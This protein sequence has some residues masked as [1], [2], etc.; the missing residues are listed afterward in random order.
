MT[1]WCI[2][3]GETGELRQL[4]LNDPADL[5]LALDGLDVIELE[6]APDLHAQEW[7]AVARL[8]R[9]KEPVL[10]DR[11]IW[12]LFTP[13]ERAVIL[14]S[15]IAE[16]RALFDALRYAP[17][18][19]PSSPWHSAGVQ[20]LVGVGLLAPERALQVLAFEPPPA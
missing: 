14:L 19:R 16:V 11:G 8:F 13:D 6:E 3:D 10:D 2:V 15:Q 5:G 9:P 12:N 1:A 4:L 18:T 7:D 20:L 17:P